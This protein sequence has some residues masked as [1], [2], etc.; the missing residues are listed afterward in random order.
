[1]NDY[2]SLRFKPR[3]LCQSRI[4]RDIFSYNSSTRDLASLFFELAINTP[5]ADATWKEPSYPLLVLLMNAVLVDSLGALS[6]TRLYTSLQY[7]FR[8][9]EGLKPLNTKLSPLKFT[10]LYHPPDYF[11]ENFSQQTMNIRYM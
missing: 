4:W 7:T 8:S 3:V 10:V 1:M 6:S 2:S 11:W 5:D 9:S